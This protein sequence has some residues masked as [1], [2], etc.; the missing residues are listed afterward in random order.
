M[1][2]FN[3]AGIHAQHHI[4]AEKVNTV[5]TNLNNPSGI[6]ELKNEL[7]ELCEFLTTHNE[8]EEKLMKSYGYHGL[9]QHHREHQKLLNTLFSLREK[10]YVSFEEAH[11]QALLVFLG[12]ELI[13]HITEDIKLGLFPI[14]TTPGGCE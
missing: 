11:K 13:E 12:T 2:S 14:T 10:I 9:E 4:L 5:C 6:D 7:D 8:E 3:V 1:G